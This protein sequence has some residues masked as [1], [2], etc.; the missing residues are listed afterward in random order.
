LL[1]EPLAKWRSL[2]E[3]G[4]IARASIESMFRRVRETFRPLAVEVWHVPSGREL[5]ISDSPAVAFRYSNDRTIVQPNVAIG[6][7]TCIT[8]PLA[9]DCLVAIGPEP[10]DEELTP[11]NV[12]L[13]NRLQVEG[14]YRYVYYRPGS[15]LKA[16]VQAIT[17]VAA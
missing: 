10:K 13:F 2:D 3:R 12:D 17:T 16:F 11:D 15:R 6:D 4:V 7:A 1:D 8:L 9:Q 5:L 14:A